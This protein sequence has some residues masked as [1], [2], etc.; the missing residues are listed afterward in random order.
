M[1]YFVLIVVPTVVLSLTFLLGGFA[2][3]TMTGLVMS[4]VYGL[5]LLVGTVAYRL[6]KKAWEW[7]QGA[8]MREMKAIRASQNPKPCYLNE[9]TRFIASLTVAQRNREI[10]AMTTRTWRK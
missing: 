5:F 8:P 7:E 9:Q 1:F 6:Y 10:A 3:S 2:H 4:G